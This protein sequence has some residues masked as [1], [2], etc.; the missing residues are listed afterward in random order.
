VRFHGWGSC[1]WEM[2]ECNDDRT[3]RL[4]HRDFLIER[5]EQPQWECRFS[6]TAA[7][8]GRSPPLFTGSRGRAAQRPPF[9]CAGN[10]RAVNLCSLTDTIHA[11]RFLKMADIMGNQE[12][13]L[14]P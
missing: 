4:P 3:F 11:L 8:H 7:A 14:Y 13:L 1:R 10:D 5:G 9:W 6:G 2:M 12:I